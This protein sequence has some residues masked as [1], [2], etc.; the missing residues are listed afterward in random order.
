MKPNVANNSTRTN[1]LFTAR[2]LAEKKK[3]VLAVSLIMVMAFMWVRVI[4]KKP[5]KA[6]EAT[7]T[8]QQNKLDERANSQLKISFIELPKVPGRNDVITR[9]FFDSK[10]WKEFIKDKDGKSLSGREEV[11]VVSKNSSEEL[12]IKIA[13]KLKLEAIELGGKP[14]AFINGKLLLVGDKLHLK[15]GVNEYEC[16]VVRI[17]ENMVLLRCAEVEIKL[18]L[19]STIEV[20]D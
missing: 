9:D 12:L 1:K 6:A 20:T 17:E 8:T 10:G 3:T 11:S 16:E 19:T 14:C 2:L 5:P 7:V 13:G 18:R 15:D 4:S